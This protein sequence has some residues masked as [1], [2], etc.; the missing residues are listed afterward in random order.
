MG[1]HRGRRHLV[2]P[3]AGGVLVE[4]LGW[5][6]IFFVNVPIGVIGLTLAVLLVPVLPT[7]PHRFD[8]VAVG[9]SGVGD[10]LDRLRFTGGT[11]GEVGAVD[12]GGDR[13]PAWGWGQCSSTGSRSIPANR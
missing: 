2:G 9:L 6:W 7:H 13:S 5:Q 10:V 3:L 4:G 12:L 11:V 1:R 8:L